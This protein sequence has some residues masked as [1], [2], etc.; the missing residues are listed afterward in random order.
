MFASVLDA[1]NISG[2][3]ITADPLLTQQKTARFVVARDA[4]YHFT[5]KGNQRLQQA[6]ALNFR[7]RAA[8]DFEQITPPDH[9]RD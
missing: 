8:A 2:R 3:I 9:G 6:I 5:V 1:I 4:H 7:H